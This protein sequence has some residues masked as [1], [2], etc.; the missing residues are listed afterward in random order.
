MRSLI[1]LQRQQARIA[2]KKWIKG[3]IKDYDD[4]VK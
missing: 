3:Q 1:D 4:Y 2:E